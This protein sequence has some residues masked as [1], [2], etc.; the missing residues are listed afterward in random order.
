M[1]TNIQ[2]F[3]QQYYPNSNLYLPHSIGGKIHV[4]FELGLG[5]DNGTQERVNQATQR[6]C[7][8]FEQTFPKDKPLWLV[9]FGY[10]NEFFDAEGKNKNHLFELV[11]Q[12]KFT[13]ETYTQLSEYT[14]PNEEDAIQEEIQ[15]T[16][17]ICQAPPSALPISAILEGIANLEMGFDPKVTQNVYFIEPTTHN[18]F[19]M[20]DD[21]GCLVY[22]T[23]ADNI[24]HLYE[25]Y[26]AW[27]V[28]YHRATIDSFFR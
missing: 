13:H 4:R 10:E 22:A 23:H 1:H 15:T 6:A 5:F 20:Y 16:L 24:R 18:I 11:G 21:R 28:D 26:N 7:T 19:Y 17:S 27:L 2:T 9:A 12:E 25:Q 8:I 3:F 14:Y